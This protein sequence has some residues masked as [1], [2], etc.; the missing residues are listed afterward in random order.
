MTATFR[1]DPAAEIE[2]P[3]AGFTLIELLVVVIIIGILAAIAIPVYLGVQNSA[4]DASA[5]S[6]LVNA[7]IALQAYVTAT[8][9]LA[10]A[11]PDRRRG[12]PDGA[13]EL[14]LGQQRRARRLD[15]HRRLRHRVLR[16][17]DE[18]QRHALLPDAVGRC[19]LDEA[20]GLPLIAAASKR[21]APHRGGP[22]RRSP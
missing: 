17:G 5:R 20:F 13:E 2:A 1:R 21:A 4:K 3:E 6:D 7:R 18:R 22:L 14:R 19:D 12:E 10:G 11:Q 8:A 9:A 15:D 16:Q